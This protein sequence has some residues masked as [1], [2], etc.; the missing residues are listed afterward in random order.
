MK[1]IFILLLLISQAV[2]AQRPAPAT[3]NNQRILLLGAT[4]H[5]GNGKMIPVSAIG[6]TGGKLS[7]VMDAKGFRP[8][9]RQTCVSGLYCFKFYFRIE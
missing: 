7:F 3:A 2:M 6:I 8:D 4:A 1:K 9:K 5:I